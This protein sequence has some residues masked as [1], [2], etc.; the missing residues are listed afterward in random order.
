MSGGATEWEDILIQHGIV[1][2]PPEQKTEYDDIV[3][4]VTEKVNTP[5]DEDEIEL[6]DDDFMI[7][8]RLKRLAELQQKYGRVYE[9]G[10][11]DFVSEVTEASKSDSVFVLL[12][13]EYVDACV[14]LKREM[15]ELAKQ[16]GNVKFVVIQATRC[17]ENYPDINLPTVL[18]YHKGELTGQYVKCSK[19]APLLS[20][21]L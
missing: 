12:Y 5:V 6:E 20:K 7:E 14:L 18:V 13:Q 1:K 3:Y 16:N 19:L 21:H 10:R 4:S 17:I 2:P 11:A 8:Y 15:E 9:I